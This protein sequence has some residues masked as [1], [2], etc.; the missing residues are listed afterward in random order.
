[1]HVLAIEYPGYGLY[2]TSKPD[3]QKIK[4]DAD[5]VYDYISQIVGVKEKDIIIAGR[6]IGTGPT[7]YLG[8]WKMAHS[9]ILISPYTSI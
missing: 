7:V 9:L 5:T 4:D 3:E 8:S 1:M 2:K 6:S